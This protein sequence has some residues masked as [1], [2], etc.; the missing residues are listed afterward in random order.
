MSGSIQRILL[1]VLTKLGSDSAVIQR[2]AQQAARA[3][4]NFSRDTLTP[5]SEKAGV[6]LGAAAKEVYLDLKAAANYL[7]SKSP[8][9]EASAR[10]EELHKR[11]STTADSSAASGEKPRQQRPFQ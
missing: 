4:H 1:G 11:A 8:P 9:T 3:Q 2:A 7:K 5:A 10:E 6:W